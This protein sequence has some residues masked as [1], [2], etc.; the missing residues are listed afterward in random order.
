MASCAA[1]AASSVCLLSLGSSWL[2]EASVV[3]EVAQYIS[4]SVCNLLHCV[5]VGFV[6]G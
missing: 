4:I 1:V 6:E 2:L 5:K 3:S